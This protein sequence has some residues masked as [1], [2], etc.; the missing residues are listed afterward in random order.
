MIV[1]ASTSP[2]R[3][4]LLGRLGLPFAVESPGVDETPAPGE[5]GRATARRLARAKALA[6]AAR[7]PRALVIGSDQVCLAGERVLGK[8]GSVDAARA[9]LAS[10]SGQQAVFATALCVVDGAGQREF[11]GCVD[12]TVDFL[13]L[14][15]AR[16]ARY[17]ERERPLDCAGSFKVE[18]L[19]ISLFES[20]RSDDPTALVG[21]PL[22]LLCRFLRDCG[23]EPL[24]AP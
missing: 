3:R 18:G 7:H 21:L 11:A 1:L 24:A 17:V 16:I 19:G 5:D 20:V 2:W 6:V 4:E 8:P 23:V 14:D 9:Q 12:T 13:D 15:P 10:L 22:I